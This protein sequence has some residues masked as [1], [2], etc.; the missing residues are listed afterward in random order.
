MTT[1]KD[2]QI[3]ARRQATVDRA[4]QRMRLPGLVLGILGVVQLLSG[5]G[6]A[7]LGTSISDF[8]VFM[9][10]TAWCLPGAL[11]LGAGLVLHRLRGWN[12]VFSGLLFTVAISLLVGGMLAFA[13]LPGAWAPLIPALAGLIL[14]VWSARLEEDHEIR[15]ARNLVYPPAPRDPSDLQPF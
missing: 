5:V 8:F 7:L 1:D 6:V 11:L 3:E 13:N 9:A 14:L 15:A 4:R 12:L 2:P 10:G